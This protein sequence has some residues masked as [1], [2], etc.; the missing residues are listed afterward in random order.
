MLAA[1]ATGYAFGLEL[2]EVIGGVER[3]SRIPGRM[4]SVQCGQD[5]PV[6]GRQRRPCRSNCSLL[7][8][9]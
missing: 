4:Q 5:F 8:C 3:M 6:Y 1:V 7:A 9:T 2:H